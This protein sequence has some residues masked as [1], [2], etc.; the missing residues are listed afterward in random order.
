[1][2]FLL[3]QSVSSPAV[4]PLLSFDSI[5]L[6]PSSPSPSLSL[7]LTPSLSLSIFFSF[8][9]SFSLSFALRSAS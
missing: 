6:H 9:L 7:S 3:P 2:L 5:D 1:M 4:S 8:S